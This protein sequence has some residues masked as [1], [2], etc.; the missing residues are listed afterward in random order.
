MNRPRAAAV[1]RRGDQTIIKR[2]LA[3]RNC[4]VLLVEQRLDFVRDITHRFAILDTGRIVA[5]GDVGELTD[6]VVKKHLGLAAVTRDTTQ[7]SSRPVAWR[8]EEPMAKSI[9]TVDLKKRPTEQPIRCRT[10]AGI[11]DI[12]VVA[13]VKPGDE[14][15]VETM[16]WTGGQ[17]KNDDN[18][19]DVRDCDLSPCHH[20][21]GPIEVQGAEP[22]DILVVDILDIGAHRGTS[23][24]IRASS[25]P[26]TAAAS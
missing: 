10:I 14:F 9:I 18:A 17:I 24:A 13:S 3:E 7:S 8:K 25:R 22:G 23:G 4:S 1:G 21:F 12:P 20:L 5:Q 26:A 15:R 6:D 11:P 16:D 19:N 2:I